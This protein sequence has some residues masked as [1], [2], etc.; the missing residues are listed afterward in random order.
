M[1]ILTK[2]EGCGEMFFAKKPKR[3]PTAKVCSDLCEPL[4][5]VKCEGC[6]EMFFAKKPKRGPTAKVCSDLCKPFKSKNPHYHRDYYR[7]HNN[8]APL[9][10]R[11]FELG[12]LSNMG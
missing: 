10:K 7:R 12:L 3:G 1:V 8:S 2:C 11:G 5:E 6:G 9:W 4:I